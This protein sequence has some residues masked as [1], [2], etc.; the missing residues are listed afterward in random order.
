MAADGHFELQ[1]NAVTQE[2]ARAQ[3][4]GEKIEFPESS[5][6]PNDWNRFIIQG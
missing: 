4:R 6:D 5:Y 2:M 3:L 1:G